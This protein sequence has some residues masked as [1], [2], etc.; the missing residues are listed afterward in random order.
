MNHIEKLYALIGKLGKIKTSEYFE[1]TYPTFL[2]RLKNPGDWRVDDVKV[3]NRLY[4][5]TFQS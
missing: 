2:A 4:D 3:I 5:E 1:M